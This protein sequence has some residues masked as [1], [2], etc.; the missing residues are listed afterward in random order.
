MNEV[1]TRIIDI[2]NAAPE[3]MQFLDWLFGAHKTSVL[4]G[5][6][7]V[8]YG[9][10]NLGKDFLLTLNKH[11]VFPVCFCNSDASKSG[12][13]FCELPVISID[14]LKQSHKESIIVIAT[15]TYAAD[16]KKYLLNNGFRRDLILWPK[17]FDMATALFFT[18]PNQLT[19]DISRTRSPHDWIDVLVKN[20]D[21]LLLAY[22]L[23]ADRKSKDLYIAKLATMLAYDNIGLFKYFISTFSEPIQEFGLVCF[24]PYGPENYFYFNNDVFCLSD[25]ET[26]VDVGAHD[27]DSVTEFVQTC[28]NRQLDYK[29]IYAFEPDPHYYAALAKNTAHLT[30]ISCHDLAIWSQTEKLRFQS[31]LGALVTG[32]SSIDKH[33][34]IEVEAV[35]LDGFL[36]GERITLLKMDPP[37]NV[38]CEAIM[39]AAETIAKFKPKLALGAYHSVEAI[40]EVPLLLRDV[41]KD[42]K[43][44]L[45][46][47]SWGIG[48]TDLFACA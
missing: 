18:P 21:R 7:V 36:N 35:S 46:H 14:E 15:Q 17:D 5:A 20:E 31:S 41:C 23:L 3:N 30:D 24:Q 43:M 28:I 29:H 45:R 12:W 25:N 6:P 32:S 27:G 19:M 42:Y 40:F 34:D 8:L 26:Y 11:G 33:G 38:V 22:N 13:V 37:G 4:A 16:V 1:I 9:T 47:N 39:G 10:G 44:Y 2:V 48:E